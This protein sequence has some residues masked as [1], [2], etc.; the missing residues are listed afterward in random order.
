MDKVAGAIP[1]PTTTTTTSKIRQKKKLEGRG[2]TL[3]EEEKGTGVTATFSSENNDDVISLGRINAF[4]QNRVGNSCVEVL[5]QYYCRPEDS[6][7]GRTVGGQAGLS[8]RH[9]L[10]LLAHNNM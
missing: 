8:F 10:V 9:N 1:T 3:T 6:H 5:V 4:V 2:N 7:N